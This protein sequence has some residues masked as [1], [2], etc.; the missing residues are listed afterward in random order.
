MPPFDLGL[1]PLFE[2][3]EPAVN[4]EAD[5]PTQ[6]IPY[7]ATGSY[8]GCP[9]GGYGFSELIINWYGYEGQDPWYTGGKLPGIPAE[10][11]AEPGPER[12]PNRGD[13][14]VG[15]PP[16]NNPNNAE[17]CSAYNPAQ[18]LRGGDGA[19]Q[20]SGGAGDDDLKSGNGTDHVRGGGGDDTITVRGGGFDRAYCGGGD[21]TIYAAR[22]D[23]IAHNCE[24]VLIRNPR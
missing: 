23:R 8:D 3:Y 10:C 14:S 17:A 18:P 24:H 15:G 16:S 12:D 21:D 5:G 9:I 11:G 4:D 6:R 2:I 7:K 22:G 20:I 19:D 13:P 1:E